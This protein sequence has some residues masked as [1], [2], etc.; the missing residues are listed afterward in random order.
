MPSTAPKMDIKPAIEICDPFK[1]LGLS[2]DKKIRNMEK[3]KVSSSDQIS[4][5]NILCS[6]SKLI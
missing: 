4:I 6:S 3:R 2:V 1:Q 5:L